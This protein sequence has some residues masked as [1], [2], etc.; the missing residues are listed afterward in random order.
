MKI[1]LSNIWSILLTHWANQ[2]QAASGHTGQTHAVRISQI[3]K[4]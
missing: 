3:E 1:E 4:A 2:A